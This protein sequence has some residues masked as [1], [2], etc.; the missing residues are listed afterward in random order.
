MIEDATER[1]LPH[2]TVLL[3]SNRTRGY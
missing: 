1:R 2:R 3:Y